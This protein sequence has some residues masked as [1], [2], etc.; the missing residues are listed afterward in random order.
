M[1][2]ARA[3]PPP[4][5]EPASAHP[6]FGW[7]RQAA[8]ASDWASV[9]GYVDSLPPGTDRSF[10]SSVIAEVDGVEHALRAWVAAAPGDVLALTLLGAREINIGWGIRTAARASKVS[11]EQFEA[12]HE[13][14][15][16][17]EQLLIRATAIDPA[18]DAAWS[19][20]LNTARGLQL[21]QHEARRRYDR[22]SEHHPSHFTAQARLLQQL[23]PKWSG[24]WEA[25][26][27]FAQECMLGAPEGAM[28]A[29]LVA[30]AHVEHALDLRD[31]RERTAYL[32][33]SH[34][35][36]ELVE[37]ARRSVLHPRFRRPYGWV[38]VQG[39]FAVLFS[40]I[41]DK[42][43]AAA[44]FHAL[45]GLASEYPWSYFGEKAETYT[46]HRAAALSHT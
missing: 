18:Y 26:H 35:H 14:L 46:R 29:G 15:R 4:D 36:A 21:G 32:R 16:R 5:F 27:G 42:A 2:P 3:L 28:S 20:R 8:A 13:H 12:F 9:R 22:L 33:Q 1:S 25:A 41:G 38:T 11:R 40:M 7:L 39:S 17:A 24:S 6:E 30:E 10:V 43:Q 23:C 44:H 37:A 34:V 45:N 19:E 31:D